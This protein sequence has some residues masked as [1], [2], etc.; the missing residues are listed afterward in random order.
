MMFLHEA[1]EEHTTNK[2]CILIG[3]MQGTQELPKLISDYLFLLSQQA[4][5][6]IYIDVPAS[7]QPVLDAFLVTGDENFLLES[8]YYFEKPTH[9]HNS[10]E[11]FDLIR[12]IGRA[13][14]LHCRNS[15]VYCVGREDDE[16]TDKHVA[17]EIL[18]RFNHHRLSV[19]VLS[20]LS[21]AK[22][23]VRTADDRL[24][25]AGFYLSS[26]LGEK[27]LCVNVYGT[28]G[29]YYHHGYVEVPAEQ[30]FEGEELFDVNVGVEWVSSANYLG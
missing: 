24:V 28:K 3:E 13:N 14:R 8:T 19:A 30:P 9:G 26:I 18:K 21:A 12:M 11:W 25:P 1:L 17:D 6:D 20:R 29:H 4:D 27:L 22:N 16:V 5:L 7:E 23:V 10:R 2:Q 15:T